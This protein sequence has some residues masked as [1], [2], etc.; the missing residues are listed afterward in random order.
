VRPAATTTY[1]LTAAGA[2]GSAA[3]TTTVTVSASWLLT[4][5]LVGGTAPAACPAG[6]QIGYHEG[7]ELGVQ[8]S[9]DSIV[10]IV[11]P[12]NYPTDQTADYEGSSSGRSVV[13]AGHY[14]D[15]DPCGG[16]HVVNLTNYGVPTSFT[17]TFSEDG[18]LLTGREIR[19]A[20]TM[21]GTTYTYE[22]EWNAALR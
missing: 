14:Y 7:S 11:D 3:A 17:G 12:S 8:R 1:R 22:Y 15:L 18:L 21:S 4:T 19:T 13:A 5:T 20:T 9:A 2:G 10:L 6:P 16:V